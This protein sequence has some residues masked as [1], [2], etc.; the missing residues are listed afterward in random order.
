MKAFVLKG[1]FSL[2]E[3]LRTINRS[4]IVLDRYSDTNKK[5]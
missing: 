4:F 1:K 5:D 3:T 2:R